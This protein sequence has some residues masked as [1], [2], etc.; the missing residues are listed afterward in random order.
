MPKEPVT[1]DSPG[2][3]LAQEDG[4]SRKP[5]NSTDG[6]GV[7]R[8]GRLVRSGC[9]RVPMSMSKNALL[10][11]AIGNGPA[12][13]GYGQ[14][15]SPVVLPVM[16][17]AGQMTEDP[18]MP[19]TAYL[20]ESLRTLHPGRSPLTAL[21]D[22][23]GANLRCLERVAEKRQNEFPTLQLF[24]DVYQNVLQTVC[25]LRQREG[26]TLPAL[27]AV[28]A[29]APPTVALATVRDWLIRTDGTASQSGLASGQ[30]EESL[31]NR[32]RG[33]RSDPAPAGLVRGDPKKPRAHKALTDAQ[34]EVWLLL[35]NREMS[36]KEIAVKLGDGWSKAD[37]IRKR[38]AAIRQAGW[39]IE[40]M[41]GRGYYRPDAPPPDFPG[42]ER[43]SG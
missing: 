13:P 42:A 14:A 26:M 8:L 11:K 9:Y 39:R 20:L 7:H 22:S 10:V 18:R 27:P 32:D 43:E 23:I 36:A 30:P 12:A 19:T 2:R 15:G 16:D 1:I 37:A 31:E 21:A 35:D 40:W 38:I 4:S 33:P 41:P 25:G 28:P 29:H 5:D 17:P 24:W 3:R 34:R 6:D